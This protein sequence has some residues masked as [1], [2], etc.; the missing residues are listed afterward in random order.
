MEKLN[1]DFLEFIKLLES[2]QVKYL[3]VGGYA[4]GLHGFPRYTG[5]IDFFIAVR[6]ENA[7]RILAVFEQFGFGG[8]GLTKNDF[9]QKDFVVEIGREPQKIQ[10]LT[11]I[12][13]VNFEEC[14]N[15]RLVFDC[16]GQK[17]KCIGLDDL[18]KN[19]RASGRAKD[20]IDVEE[21]SNGD[22]SG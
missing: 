5:D 13:G 9:L 18:L 11:G 12:D 3:I 22:D 20:L 21:L 19:K 1:R 7:A 2:N 4:V 15:R 16:D 10:V 8:I 14:F 6:E 17:M